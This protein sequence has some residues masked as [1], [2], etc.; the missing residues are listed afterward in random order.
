MKIILT[1]ILLLLTIT[2]FGQTKNDSM[3]VDAINKVRQDPKSFIPY[4][5]ESMKS[6]FQIYPKQEIIDLINVLKVT[7]PLPILVWNN[8]MYLITKKWADYLK[9][10]NKREHNDILNNFKGFKIVQENLSSVGNVGEFNPN[11]VL[12]NLLVDYMVKGKGHR[13]NILDP[14]WKYISVSTNDFVCVQNFGY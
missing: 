7:K 14:R 10:E 13:K 1:Y 6:P 11:G 2:S 8:D 4:L 9:S 5:E 12:H 3:M